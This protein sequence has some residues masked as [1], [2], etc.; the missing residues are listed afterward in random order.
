MWY[1]MQQPRAIL[2]VCNVWFWSW[3][4]VKQARFVC[5]AGSVSY[6]TGHELVLAMS[7]RGQILPELL[8]L[9]LVFL[10]AQAYTTGRKVDGSAH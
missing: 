1:G 7:G 10:R 6:D 2:I 8:A 5:G 3:S 9:R 4:T